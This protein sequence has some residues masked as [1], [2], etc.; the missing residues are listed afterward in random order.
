[1]TDD[2]KTDV[3]KAEGT[4]MPPSVVREP[5]QAEIAGA[6]D[7][8]PEPDAEPEPAA[9]NTRTAAPAKYLPNDKPWLAIPII[10]AAGVLGLA[11]GCFTLGEPA[12]RVPL[13]LLAFVSGLT[14]S[15]LFM[16]M[17]RWHQIALAGVAIVSLGV[18]VLVSIFAS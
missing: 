11:V 16:E 17:K 18:G 10:L 3:P 9:A 12:E 8:T 15:T 13:G 7:E 6:S 4:L 2:A 1:M 5:S 14:A